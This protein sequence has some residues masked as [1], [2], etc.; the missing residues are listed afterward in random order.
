MKAKV[1]SSI[2][3]FVFYCVIGFLLYSG[4]DNI[5]RKTEVA[6]YG[7]ASFVIVLL[8]CLYSSVYFIYR[9]IRWVCK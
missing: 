8:Y 7:V 2:A 3:I 4:I 5:L 1:I 6:W 9:F